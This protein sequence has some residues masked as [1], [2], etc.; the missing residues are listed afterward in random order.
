MRK[1]KDKEEPKFELAFKTAAQLMEE[2]K[3]LKKIPTC[4]P[5][6]NLIGGGIEEGELIE[7]SGEYGAGKSQF[8]HTLICTIIVQSANEP[9]VWLDTEGT[10]KPERLAEIAE[11]RGLNV[12]EALNR[13]H[14]L[15]PLSTA[16]QMEALKKIAEI[17]PK[18]IIVDSLI[19]LYREE[20]IGRENLPERQ[21]LLRTFIASLKRYVRENNCVAVATNQVIG[22]PEVLPFMTYEQRVLVCGG[23]TVYHSIDA[24][25]Q[26][27]K[28]KENK[29]VARLIDSSRYPTSEV[30]FRIT[31]KG[32]EPLEE[33]G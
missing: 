10:F 5:I 19:T 33:D 15:Q 21:G 13:V 30:R 1:K 31:E 20:Y 28:A 8:C 27:R 4:T 18:L 22:N 32:V 25:I 3:N 14:V 29:R 23:H 26:I 11:K 16:A 6:D 7:V 2:R 17:K 9:V 24:R 12:E